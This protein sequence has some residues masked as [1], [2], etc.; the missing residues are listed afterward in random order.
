MA[1]GASLAAIPAATI[2]VS[3]RLFTAHDQGF[4]SVAVMASTFLSQLVFAAVVESRLSTPGTDRRVAIP[5]WLIAVAAIAGVALMIGGH[6]AIVVC[7]CLP[8][9]LAVL[10]VGRGVSIAEQLHKREIIAA[11]AV[12]V[13]AA[14]AVIAGLAGSPWSFV[15]LAGGILVGTAARSIRVDHKASS[16]SP[17]IRRWV[18]LD[19]GIT[20][21]IY[22][23]INALILASLGPI[24][25]VVFAA[26]STV[27]GLIAIPLNYMRIRLLKSHSGREIALTAAAI[28]FA[29]LVI[30]VLELLGVL[31]FFFGVAWNS[32]ETLVP[33]LIACAWRSA[34]LLT[35]I[36]FAA[37]RRAGAVRVV[38]ALR[39]TAA[40]VTLVASW[41]VLPLDQVPLVF[42]VLL[43]GELLQASLYEAARRRLGVPASPVA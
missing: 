32:S 10:E 36:P 23:A 31:G 22:P 43:A 42:A 14:L 3:S 6:S 19:V 41:A 9:L 33:L 4:I 25:A 11:V 28:G 2:S 16:A 39:A 24:A 12:G 18:I 27:S 38:T 13:G 40:V 5:R 30:T 17:G 8:F 34:S 26:I 1:G 20:G 7:L 29:V 15:P 37:L 21:A 35:T